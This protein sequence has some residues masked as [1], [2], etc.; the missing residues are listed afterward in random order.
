MTNSTFVG[1]F[2]LRL[3]GFALFA[4]TASAIGQEGLRAGGMNDVPM[5][6]YSVKGVR[7]LSRFLDFP[8]EWVKSCES[9]ILQ[10]ETC[11]NWCE[12]NETVQPIEA[13][14]IARGCVVKTD[15]GGVVALVGYRF[16]N[17]DVTKKRITG[18]NL[19][20][21]GPVDATSY[22]TRIVV[23]YRPSDSE[24]LRQ[25]LE[26]RFG[27]FEFDA[28][29]GAWVWHST[30]VDKKGEQIGTETITFPKAN[31]KNLYI[32][33]HNFLPDEKSVGTF[34]MD[35]DVIRNWMWRNVK[36]EQDKKVDRIKDNF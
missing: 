27:K 36:R 6:S 21:V 8:E 24:L 13:G 12:K 10:T 20:L 29:A 2:V 30:I 1:A 7:L 18:S 32:L 23:H 5:G 28:G 3:V 11:W 22:L 26:K 15:I 14:L 16:D 25:A 33:H 4:S 9:G 35:T 19:F 31:T 34:V 17:T